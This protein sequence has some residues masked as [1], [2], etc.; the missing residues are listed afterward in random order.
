MLTG[1]RHRS[2]HRSNYPR[3]WGPNRIPSKGT[4]IRGRGPAVADRPRRDRNLCG[5]QKDYATG[6]R[7]E[8]RRK[9]VSELNGVPR[10]RKVVPWQTTKVDGTFR[11]TLA[12]F[13]ISRDFSAAERARWP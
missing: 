11:V 7:R 1:H 8:L 9:L 13:P 5:P 3:T 4:A 2:T 6:A 10:L 12:I